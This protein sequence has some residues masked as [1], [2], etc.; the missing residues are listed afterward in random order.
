[1]SAPP[2]A[3]LTRR[4][5]GCRS[6]CDLLRGGLR[7]P[8]PRRVLPPHRGLASR[9]PRTTDLVVDTVEMAIWSRARDGLTDLTRLVHHTD[10]GSQ[11]TSF[12]VTSRLLEA[13]ADASVG[14]VG[15]AHDNALAE[16]QIGIHKTEL[17]GPEGLGRV[18]NTSSCRRCT[19]STGSTANASMT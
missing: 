19:G 2:T 1:M 6:G 12:A 18:W 9:H 13:G 11:I 15:D 3:V 14:S 7:G 10:A 17:N 16:S 8:R 5:L 4:L